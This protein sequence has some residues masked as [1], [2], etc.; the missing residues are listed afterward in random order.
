MAWEFHSNSPI[1]AQVITE[2]KKQIVAGFLKSGTKIPSVRDLAKEAGVNPNTIQRAVSELER[3]QLVFAQR[4]AGRFVTNDISL[5]EDKKKKIVSS[6]LPLAHKTESP[7]H[8]PAS[9]WP[10]S[11][12]NFLSGSQRRFLAHSSPRVA[13]SPCPLGH[14]LPPWPTASPRGDHSLARQGER[15]G[16]HGIKPDTL[17]FY[18]V[19]HKIGA[20][21]ACGPNCGPFVLGF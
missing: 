4:T 19:A 13:H 6:L 14:N 8:N 2:I 17:K 15:T 11:G 10:T 7:A 12:H 20:S 1:Y 18:E 21:V 3:E 9:K 16:S 5:I